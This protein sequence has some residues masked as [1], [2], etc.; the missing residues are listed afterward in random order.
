[1]PGPNGGLAQICVCWTSLWHH[2]FALNDGS[3]EEGRSQARNTLHTHQVITRGKS[4]HGVRS[5]ESKENAHHLIAQRRGAHLH[6]SRALSPFCVF[7]FLFFSASL[8]WLSARL[9]I[10]WKVRL[11]RSTRGGDWSPQSD[12]HDGH[13]QRDGGG[14]TQALGPW[15][16]ASQRT[17]ARVHIRVHD[18]ASERISAV[19]T[20]RA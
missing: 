16:Q 3:R 19:C 17:A 10:M 2:D 14:P 11:E 12:R 8:L 18:F 15:P 13:S 7:C 5:T 20:F 4:D 9:A 1:V 6:K